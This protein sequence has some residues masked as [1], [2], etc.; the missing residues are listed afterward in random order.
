MKIADCPV[1]VTADVVG[2]KWKPLILLALKSKRRRFN[3]LRR[4]VPEASHKVLTEQL[5]A[6]ESCGV[7]TRTVHD[8][9]SRR[10]EYS[11]SEYGDSLRPVLEAMAQWGTAHRKR[12]KSV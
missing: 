8:A 12:G 1:R 4:L 7:I 5:R 9:K 6:L 11:F 10:V 2:G 3:E